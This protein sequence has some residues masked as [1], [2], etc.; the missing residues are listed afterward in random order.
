MDK[1]RENRWEQKV[2]TLTPPERERRYQ[3]RKEQAYAL[4]Y[5]LPDH[6]TALAQLESVQ[7]SIKKGTE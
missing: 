3:E 1:E 4:F 7:A 5:S 2:I 6:K